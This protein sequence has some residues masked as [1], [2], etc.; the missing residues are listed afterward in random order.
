MKMILL[1]LTTTW[2]WPSFPSE[3]IGT[4]SS[5]LDL[6]YYFHLCVCVWGWHQTFSLKSLQ[7]RY[8]YFPKC[9]FAWFNASLIA[10]HCH[11]CGFCPISQVLE[12]PAVITEWNNKELQAGRFLPCSVVPGWLPSG[13][14]RIWQLQCQG[15]R[16]G[17][18]S[19]GRDMQP[20]SLSTE[21]PCRDQWS[22]KSV[23]KDAHQG[24]GGVPWA[25]LCV[26]DRLHC[27]VHLGRGKDRLD[28]CPVGLG[29]PEHA[30]FFA[31]Q[32]VYSCRQWW[33][34]AAVPRLDRWGRPL[35]GWNPHW[36]LPWCQFY[37]CCLSGAGAC[38]HLWA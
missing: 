20:V 35:T 28:H 3:L 23:E 2:N 15:V 31:G 27:T 34:P 30:V 14:P 17:L 13:V 26:C 10:F 29:D 25:C 8:F 19:T 37:F 12:S 1:I 16:W 5:F 4:E 18:R 7:S 32:K 11:R 24:T 6:L 21:R 9:I 38:S 22:R 33:R 36:A